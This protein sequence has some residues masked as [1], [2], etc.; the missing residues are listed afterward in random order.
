M[1]K[2]KKHRSIIVSSPARIHL[3]FFG[4]ENNYGYSFGSM[5]LAINKHKTSVKI[6]NA[7]KFKTNLPK[8]FENKIKNIIKSTN[9]SSR[10]E[11]SLL[12]QLNSHI[13]LGSGTQTS[14]C[15]GKAISNYFNLNLTTYELVNFFQR[16][17][18][19]GTG[20]GIFEKGGF[21]LDSC[22]KV[23][24][25]PKI[26]IRKKFPADWRL[27]LVSDTDSKGSYFGIREKKFFL[28][29]KS[30]KKHVSDLSHITLRGII[31]SIMYEDYNYFVENIAEFQKIT[32]LYYKK[33]Q[34][35]TFASKKISIIMQYLK[36]MGIVGTGQ[37]SWGP[38]SYIFAESTNHA[39]EIINILNNK[40]S[41]Y[42]SLKYEIVKPNNSGYSLKHNN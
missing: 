15:I 6:L 33:V 17:L 9:I 21:V 5:G 19:S 10:F 11:I 4:I 26:I 40:F 35:G 31:P 16:G 25:Y 29:D 36:K 30:L 1:T 37:S 41:M 20:I 42:N 24:E 28:N 3:G 8:K 38:S 12:N 7:H 23:G 27:I 2:F 13:G 14:L 22:K 39:K 18:R 32:S 34:Q